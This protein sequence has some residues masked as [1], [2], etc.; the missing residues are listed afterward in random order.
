MPICRG[1]ADHDPTPLAPSRSV[2]ATD[3]AEHREEMADHAAEHEEVPH[4]VRVFARL[5]DVERH[6]A[7]VQ[8]AARDDPC[9]LTGREALAQGLDRHNDQPS[10]AEIERG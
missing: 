10:H 5:P 2:T 8:E 1:L 9:N 4:R 6:A 7:G 3:E